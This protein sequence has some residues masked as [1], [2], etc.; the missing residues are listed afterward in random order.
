MLEQN[1]MALHIHTHAH[2]HSHTCKFDDFL[3]V[4]ITRIKLPAVTVRV[5]IVTI[6]LI[7]YDV[8]QQVYVCTVKYFCN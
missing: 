1:F 7:L 6:S 2:I 5:F 8:Q 3:S 4:K